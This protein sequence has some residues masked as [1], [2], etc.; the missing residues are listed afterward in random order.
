MDALDGLSDEELIEEIRERPEE[1]DALR[2]ALFRRAYPRV[3]RFCLRFCGN[4]ED[5]GDLAQ[6]VF[7]KVH[8]R[9]HSFRGQSR[10]ST[11]LYA[12]SRNTAL[13]WAAQNRRRRTRVLQGEPETF[14]DP[15]AS[16][17]TLVE[18]AQ[19]GAKLREAMARDL[20]PLEAKILYLHHVDGLTLPS[21]T[22]L[23]GLENRSGA[24]AYI[25]SA[26]RKLRR[27]FGRWLRSQTAE[28]RGERVGSDDLSKS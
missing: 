12:V 27:K 23:L 15:R 9:L 5:A 11:W 4:A 10:F 25:V 7:L 3:A 6:E 2:D 17:E 24:K 28:G 1:S 14:V 19:I 22:A 20:D 13:N 21:I 8:A 18:R 16:T 26:T